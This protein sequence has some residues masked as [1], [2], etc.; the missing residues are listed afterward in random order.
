MKKG[1]TTF[2]VLSLLILLPSISFAQRRSA[3]EKRAL[4]QKALQAAKLFTQNE[5]EFKN[6]EVPEKWKKESAVVLS[7]KTEYQYKEVKLVLTFEKTQR[8]RI[9]LLDE[10]A[11][12]DFSELYY[13]TTDEV[14]IQVIKKDGT[15]FKVRTDQAVLVENYLNVPKKFRNL[16]EEYNKLAIPNLE[17]GDIIDYYYHFV[18]SHFNYIEY[19]FEPLIF[20]LPEEYPVIYQK[21]DLIVQYR[22][23]Y[24]N[25]NSFNGAGELTVTESEKDKLR[26]YSFVDRNRDKLKYTRFTYDQLSEPMIKF[27]VIYATKPLKKGGRYIVGEM[28]EVKSHITKNEI[29]EYVTRMDVF[30]DHIPGWVQTFC[31]YVTKKYKGKDIN[32]TKYLLDTYYYL[33]FYRL[34]YKGYENTKYADD[35]YYFALLMKYMLDFKDIKNKIVVAV[36]R[37]V[38]SLNNLVMSAELVWLLK[39]NIGKDEY[40]IFNQDRYSNIDE[41]LPSVEGSIAFAVVPNK[42]ESEIRTSQIEVPLTTFQDNITIEEMD[43]SLTDMSIAKIENKTI[44]KGT[45]KYNF[46]SAALIYDDYVPADFKKYGF[47]EFPETKNTTKLREQKRKIQGRKT[48]DSKKRKKKFENRLKRDFTV[49]SYDDFELLETGIDYKSDSLV[50]IE[51]YSLGDIVKRV[52]EN[53]MLEIGKLIGSQIELGENEMERDKDF[54]IKYPSTKEYKINFTMPDGYS[55]QGLDKLS[56][57]VGNETGSFVSTA[58]MEGNLLKVTVEK[59][60]KQNYQPKENWSK[61]V[62]FLEAAY[63]FTQVKVLMKRD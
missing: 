57:N 6:T 49:V 18:N 62:D 41:S 4:S 35:G 63:D 30:Y 10:A 60:Y 53:Y 1:E 47:S 22:K 28:D 12:E 2:L 21:V 32:K 26:A 52:G 38:E 44:V 58:K 5:P 46:Y 27:Q 3:S 51:K 45:S 13:L 7:R 31:D 16:K 56:V 61:M 19:T 42:K 9:K 24:I 40:F 17:V 33:R 20:I 39:V 15:V 34:S 25:F 48:E 55:I 29:G 54:Y 43:V 23:F 8:S 36:P 11:V 50:F 14:V 37:S 59:I